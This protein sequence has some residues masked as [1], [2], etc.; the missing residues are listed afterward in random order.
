[1]KKMNSTNRFGDTRQAY[2]AP[3][4]TLV[5]AS[6]GVGKSTIALLSAHV[7]ARKVIKTALVEADLQF[8]D[9][10]F[11]LGLDAGTSSLSLGMACK[12]IPISNHLDLYKAP[13]LPEVAEQISDS[14]AE[15]VRCLR[16]DYALVIADTGQFWS[17]LTGDLLCSS[18]LV[19]VVMDQRKA[20]VYGAIKALELCQ[21]LNIP[22]ARIAC[23]LNRATGKSRSEMN[24]IQRLLNHVELFQLADGKAYVESLVSTA[25]VEE[26]VEGEAAPIP[27][28]NSLLASLLPRAGISFKAD[29][30]KKTRRF[31]A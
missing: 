30:P 7:A 21:R 23:V 29:N 26:L 24:R 3:L 9:M 15:L 13:P 22:N 14:A 4:I 27:D 1:M 6:G 8:G 5:S 16:S 31:F 25:R 28:I 17:G 2:Q 19:L 10:G 11:W 20:S 12:P 18:D